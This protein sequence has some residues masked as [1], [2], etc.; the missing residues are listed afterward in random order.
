MNL[1]IA[2]MPIVCST[3][4]I[5]AFRHTALRAGLQGLFFTVGIILLW[6]PFSLNTT[7]FLQAVTA[8]LYNT[9]NVSYVLLGGV[10]LFQVL[11]RGG[12]LGTIADS[13]ASTITD[14]QH[15]LF[16]IV[17]G[18][19]VFF[20]SVT[21][22]GVGIVVVAPLLIALGYQPVQAA[23][24]A[25]LGQCAVPWGALAV[26]TTLGSELSGVTG[27]RL[28]E[29]SVFIS[30]PYLLLCGTVALLASGL[31]N[32][33]I[34]QVLWLVF[35][36]TLLSLLLWIC[37]LTLGIELA[38]CVAGLLLTAVAVLINRNRQQPH[39]L[40]QLAT[41]IIPFAI[42]MTALIITRFYQ[43]A[44]DL[45]QRHAVT[46]GDY[47]IE[48][49]YHP[50]FWLIVA[51]LSGIAFLTASRSHW[52]TV[53]RESTHQWLMASLAVGGFLLFGQLMKDAGMTQLIA[54]AIAS[55]AGPYYAA[56]VPVIGGLGGFLTAS[57]AASN[58]LFMTLQT[59]AASQIGLPVD[60]TAAVQNTAGSNCSMASPGR[61]VF[62]ASI[63]GT[64]GAEA[65]LLRRI[66]PVA[67]AGV[68]VLMLMSI[69]LM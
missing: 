33:R 7:D 56:V 55:A 41:A 25:L 18:I 43:P 38:G 46:F 23:V 34:R 63:A 50:G 29:I 10:F 11:D 16:A 52:K 57:N 69:L 58:A 5:L 49:L 61:L 3:L 27:H 37:S 24:L 36:V 68:L 51:A 17:F 6:P 20:E 15:S 2:S 26:G 62:A 32:G 12:S 22:F 30:Y 48:P 31:W 45:L 60:V 47:R 35:Y 65:D 4:A 40:A 64:P 9:L 8:G 67:M 14:P 53:I 42:L 19:S 21:G 54:Q 28:A 13:F 44:A 1:L 39:A 59:S 66:M